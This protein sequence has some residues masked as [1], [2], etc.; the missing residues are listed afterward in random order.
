MTTQDDRDLAPEAASLSAQADTLE[1]AAQA[2]ADRARVTRD[3]WLRDQTWPGR[4][5]VEAAGDVRNFL[6]HVLAASDSI[7]QMLGKVVEFN[8]RV[9]RL[10]QD[11]ASGRRVST[12][13]VIQVLRRLVEHAVDVSGGLW[14]AFIPV[15][16]VFGSADA[17]VQRLRTHSRGCTTSVRG[18]ASCCEAASTCAATTFTTACGEGT[19]GRAM[20]E[21]L[22]RADSGVGLADAI[23]LVKQLEA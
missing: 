5:M 16:S 21:R 15:R 19:S 12:A 20:A 22:M 13:D 8:G 3:V 1:R 9:A 2:A 18:T 4:W 10:P 7:T 14:H 17:G 11:Q 23:A 6:A